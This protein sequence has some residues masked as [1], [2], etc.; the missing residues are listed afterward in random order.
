MT[1]SPPGYLS[2]EEIFM[3][4]ALRLDNYEVHS[5]MLLTNNGIILDLD[6]GNRSK[7][8][9]MLEDPSKIVGDHFTIKE[10]NIFN[11]E[12]Y[13]ETRLTCTNYNENKYI[14][15]AKIG[16]ERNFTIE[17]LQL[18]IEITKTWNLIR[19]SLCSSIDNQDNKSLSMLQYQNQI[20]SIPNA[21][22]INNNNWYGLIYDGK[23]PSDSVVKPIYPNESARENVFINDEIVKLLIPQTQE[24][25]TEKAFHMQTPWLKVMS[26]I[27]LKYGKEIKRKDVTIE[28]L[29]SDMKNYIN[30]DPYLKTLQPPISLADMKNMAKFIRSPEQRGGRSYNPQS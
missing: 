17:Y 3:K 12:D 7:I 25:L 30:N 16:R 13:K 4:V 18:L 11:Q 10:I 22:W 1:Y 5:H 19:N 27:S 23:L 29:V 6:D 24:S 8:E 15:N 26:A 21:T 20:H 2:F 28:S 14:F 9:R